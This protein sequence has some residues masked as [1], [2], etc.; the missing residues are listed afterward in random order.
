MATKPS[1]TASRP[2]RSKQKR[3]T[4]K[5]KNQ[6]WLVAKLT[7]LSRAQ[8]V[9]L[10]FVVMF[11][12]VGVAYTALS[13][14][15]TINATTWNTYAHGLRQCESGNRYSINTG[16]GYYGA[17]QF[18]LA[19]WNSVGGY[20][21]TKYP[22]NAPKA[23]QDYY[24]YK[25]FKSRGF[26]PW[27]C[28]NNNLYPTRIAWWGNPNHYASTG[29][30]STTTTTGTVNPYTPYCPTGAEN[31]VGYNYT[32]RGNCVKKLQ[33]DLNK[34]QG[35]GLVIDGVFGPKTYE[36]LRTFQRNKG[37]VVDGICGKIT[38]AKLNT[39]YK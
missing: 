14:A 21:Y 5:Q 11:G 12:V 25:L 18:N 17:Y 1:K 6:S 28:W 33:W 34:I 3:V 32:T 36:A 20:T 38:W 30:L 37:L 9:G 27:S 13:R 24:A 26:Q 31:T 2:T 10:V 29:S 4:K 7:S 16:N 39:Y 19:T 35:A 15:Y 23:V 8:M 22:H